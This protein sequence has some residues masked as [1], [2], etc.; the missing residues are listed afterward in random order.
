MPT[1]NARSFG[2]RLIKCL[3]N[4]LTISHFEE[5]SNFFSVTRAGINCTQKLLRGKILTIFDVMINKIW[6]RINMAIYA[7]Y[8]NFCR[9][10]KHLFPLVFNWVTK[11]GWGQKRRLMKTT[12]LVYGGITQR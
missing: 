9:T 11:W 3:F 1:L 7:C 4:I 12:C 2:S 5:F 8:P 10:Q 6:C